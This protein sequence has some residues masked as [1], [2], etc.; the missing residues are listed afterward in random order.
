[1]PVQTRGAIVREDPKGEFEIVDLEVDDPRPGEIQVKM[2][3][4]GMC[5]S[6]D[7]VAQG[8]LPLLHY[9]TCCGHEGAGIVTAVGQ[10]T[11]GFTEGDHVVFTFIPACGKCRWCAEGRQYLCDYN[12]LA[13][14]GSRFDEP[15]SFRYRLSDGTPVGQLSALGTFAGTT[16][17]SALSA[18]KIDKSIPFEA[19]CLTG[20]AVGTGWGS[21]VR[22]GNVQA[23][24]TV[25]VVG[26]G[27]IGINAVQGAAFVGAS[28]V[29]AVDP[30][31]F[32]RETAVALGAT[33]AYASMGE[34]VEFAR[35]VTN[36]Q[37]ADVVIVTV[38][39]IAGDDVVQGLDAIRKAGTL[40]VTSQGNI[41][42]LAPIPAVHMTLYAKR[43]Q[44]ALYG[45][46]NPHADIPRMLRLYQEGRLK[47]DELVTNRYTLDQINLGYEDMRAGKN[48][49]GVI[50]FD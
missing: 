7:H 10:N 18:V 24:D 16:T 13:V 5:H 34:A 3:A 27:G 37:G 8:D 50:V 22:A 25:I 41:E 45:N 9:P 14:V 15:G 17:V 12:S 48:I 28:H 40:V 42:T 11:P 29:I 26:I 30:I 39:I 6:D 35:S 23:G 38:G 43:I 2:A 31:A 1:M 21:A 19:A 32:K 4:S 33:H 47:L 44:G 36:G 49:R 46:A 20:C